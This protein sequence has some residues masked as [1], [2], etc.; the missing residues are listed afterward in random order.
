MKILLLSLMILSCTTVLAQHPEDYRW[1]DRFG[2]PGIVHNTTGSISS[3]ISSIA[4]DTSE[5]YVGGEFT[6]AGNNIA[7]WVRATKKWRQLGSGI[8]GKVRAMT[9]IGDNV[10]VGG[11]FTKAGD[12]AADNIAVWNKSTGT[13]SALGKGVNG[14]VLTMAVF[15]GELHIGGLFTA[16]GDST[17]NK[18][19]RWT[20]SEWKS[21]GNGTSRGVLFGQVNCLSAFQNSLWVGGTFD[22]AG[23]IE[24][25]E[26][27][28]VWNGNAWSLPP[29]LS[30]SPRKGQ[31]ISMAVAGSKLFVS[32]SWDSLKINSLPTIRTP[33]GLLSYDGNV[34]DTP[35]QSNGN[36]PV[37]PIL[38]SSGQNLYIA[39][40]QLQEVNGILTKGI[41]K[42]NAGTKLWSSLGSG[43]KQTTTVTGLAAT[44]TEVVVGG[45]IIEAGGQ[46]VNNIGIFDVSDNTWQTLA[47]SFTLGLLPAVGDVAPVIADVGGLIAV[48]DFQFAGDTRVNGLARWNGTKWQPIATGFDGQ[49]A[50]RTVGI[51]GIFP[52][53]STVVQKGSSIIIGGDFQGIGTVPAM[54]LA[55][56]NNGVV[57]EIGG[58]I[59]GAF[60]ATNSPGYLS[61]ESI[62]V[63]SGNIYVGGKFLNAG[64][65]T[66]NCI[67]KWNGTQWSSLGGGVTL[68]N[69]IYTSVNAI[70]KAPNG[71]IYIGGNF[72]NAGGVPVDGVARWDGNQWHNVGQTIPDE[73]KM[74]VLAM[75][76]VGNDLYIGGIFKRA[77]G[78]L[79]PSIAKW[80]GQSW[81][82]LGNGLGRNN[83]YAYVNTFTVKGDEL[84]VGGIFD[85]AGDVASKNIAVWNTRTS[86]WS[87]LG[88]G[89]NKGGIGGQVTSI[90]IMHDTVFCGGT[91][92]NAGGKPSFNIAAWLPAKSNSIEYISTVAT[93][94]SLSIQPNP[95]SSTAT[96][97][98]TIPQAER[99]T[100]SLR[101]ALGREVQRISEGEL[102]AGEYQAQIDC[103]TLASG[104]YFCVVSGLQ[105]TLT[106]LFIHSK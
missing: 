43:L 66:A 41:A 61:V 89:V 38:A 9:I 49:F 104:A 79:A 77:N 16:A 67:A 59:S 4:I 75:T 99:V 46:F 1:D 72:D 3:P 36:Y 87:A 94:S 32:G 28:A 10:Y 58:G 23:G 65:I 95:T 47:G 21:L 63:D 35:I 92:D 85:V 19:A 88:S 53:I 13:W 68:S 14:E 25:G 18:I 91:I 84:Y 60:S 81:S 31:V 74:G 54:C 45:S 106:T 64:P 27:L 48:G 73:W 6:S 57:T 29:K 2:A 102:Q 51:V 69:A 12:V 17:M 80:D 39:N 71:D 50:A 7:A 52:S 20:G 83:G 44:E 22:A 93:T 103:S 15:N 105:T 37:I 76:F 26:R 100:I 40:A 101:D 42:W 24:T 70:V 5:I 78:V 30:S 34:W 33:N 90:V 11:L 56:F 82:P 55:E 98:F 97:T 86:S 8:T 62:L 96:I